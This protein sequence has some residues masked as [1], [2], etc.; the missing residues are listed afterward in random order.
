[1]LFGF[2]V[3]HLSLHFPQLVQHVIFHEPLESALNVV[4]AVIVRV[5]YYVLVLCLVHEETLL[6]PNVVDMRLI[7]SVIL[8]KLE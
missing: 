8:L 3:D 7:N 1:M 2:I 4:Q 5:K 6:I